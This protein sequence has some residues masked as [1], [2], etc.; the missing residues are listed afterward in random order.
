[1]NIRNCGK[2]TCRQGDRKGHELERHQAAW[3]NRPPTTL[4]P[5]LESYF[6]ITVPRESKARD[7]PF[8]LRKRL[9]PGR[10]SMKRTSFTSRSGSIASPRRVIFPREGR[11]GASLFGQQLVISAGQVGSVEDTKEELRRRLARRSALVGL[12]PGQQERD[13]V[14]TPRENLP[15]ALMW[16]SN[17]P[18]VS[19]F[20]VTSRIPP[21]ACQQRRFSLVR[22]PP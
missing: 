9:P 21:A 5:R 13:L 20:V 1:M 7:V 17:Q 8:A 15:L 4:F 18:G 2:R 14:R 10:L 6:L 3:W 16:N 12:G 22:V 11:I 19:R